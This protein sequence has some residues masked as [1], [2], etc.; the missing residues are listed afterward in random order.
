LFPEPAR[1]RELS[2]LKESGRALEQTT[3]TDS[4]P[5]PMFLT[6]AGINERVRP[7]HPMTL[8]RALKAG[9]IKATLHGNAY[10]YDTASVIAWMQGAVPP[11]KQRPT[12][13]LKLRRGRPRK[14]AAK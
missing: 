11:K 10:H 12:A 5:I 7:C 3:M 8:R 1:K 14:E 4:T 9:H 6:A 13:G 2:A